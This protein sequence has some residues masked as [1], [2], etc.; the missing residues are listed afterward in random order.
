[1]ADSQHSLPLPPTDPEVVAAADLGSNSF[2]LVVAEVRG[3]QLVFVD[4]RKEFVRLAGGLDER[5]RL[6]PEA[7]SR[8]L[9][10]LGRFGERV[11]SF[12]PGTVRVV[13]TNTLRQARNARDLLEAAQRSLGH[14][15]EIV[16]GLE[17]ARLIYLGVSRSLAGDERRL[18]VDIGGGSTEL[19]VGEGSRPLDLES[20]YMGCVSFSLRHFPNG[21]VKEKRWQRAEIAALQELEPVERRFRN[22]AGWLVAVGSSGTVRSVAEVVQAAGWCEQGITHEALLRLRELLLE[23]GTTVQGG[24]KGLSDGRAP[25]FAGGVAVLLAVFKALGIEQMRVAGGAL[26]EGA[27]Y[28]LLGRLH[29][30]DTRHAAVES[31]ARRYHVQPE[32]AERVRETALQL[33]EQCA[34]SWNLT[35]ELPWL[36]LSWGAQLHEVGLDINHAGFHKHGAYIVENAEMH[37]FSLQEHLLL[38]SLVRSHRRKFPRQIFD[39]LPSGWRQ[40]ARR[41]AVLL[42]LAAVL[43]RSRRDEPLAVKL[44]VDGRDLRLILPAAWLEK[45]PLTRADLRQEARYLAAAR[46]RLTVEEDG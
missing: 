34:E 16:S 44:E 7:T 17:E 9:D 46:Y 36:M 5:K 43:H 20:L 38:A 3:G 2:H 37:G 14:P 12:P 24:I 10:C 1:M 18:V 40:P 19:I 45:S 6:T 31:M 23:Q 41:G 4:R 28:D 13:G 21:R 25:V 26:R 30:E 42:R 29:H 33:L 22:G 11:R 39:R 35:G 32:Q 27:L 8:A 15:V